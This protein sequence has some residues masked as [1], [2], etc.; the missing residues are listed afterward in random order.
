MVLGGLGGVSLLEEVRHQRR[1]LNADRFA[2]L[3]ARAFCF[4]LMVKPS[5]FIFAVKTVIT[6]LLGRLESLFIS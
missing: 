3:P 2:S 4:M 1:A 6:H 5:L